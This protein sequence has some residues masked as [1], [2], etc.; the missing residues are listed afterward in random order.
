MRSSAKLFISS[1][2]ASAALD[3]ML[4]AFGAHAL[5]GRL[6][7]KM[8]GV[9]HTGVEYQFYHALGV[10]AVGILRKSYADSK[11]LRWSGMLMAVGIVLFSG[12]HYALSLSG[13]RRFGAITPVGGLAFIA[14]WIFL[15]AAVA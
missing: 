5:S 10:V 12:S 6:S 9:F 13:E 14:A 1:G 7:P 2:A 15:I 11:S 8:L 4:G 3:V